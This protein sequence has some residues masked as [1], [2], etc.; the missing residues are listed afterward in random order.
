MKKTYM[1]L[2][3]LLACSIMAT[4]ADKDL[5][6]KVTGADR[7]KAC[8]GESL[9]YYDTLDPEECENVALVDGDNTITVPDQLVLYITPVNP[10]DL[11]SFK[12]RDGDPVYRGNSG[13]YEIHN[14][15]TFY[16]P[17]TIVCASE[18]E[19][20]NQSVTI[21]MDDCSKVKI[22]RADQKVFEPETNTITIP[23]NPQ[24]ESRLEIRP[25]SSDYQLYKVLVDG[26]EAT[27]GY[28][29]FYA[30]LVDYSG[31]EPVYA[32]NIDV[33]ANYPE[34]FKFKVSIELDAPQE[35][36]T[37]IK[38]DGKEVGNID[39]YLTAEGFDV[40]PFTV[41]A[42]GLD[43]RNYDITKLTDNDATKYA[44]SQ[45]TIDGIDCDHHIVIAGKKLSVYNVTINVTGA[46]GIVAEYN[47]N[48]ITFVEGE[49]TL[50]AT[51]TSNY[52]TI[53]QADGWEIRS[54]TDN[55]GN[56]YL[57]YW[58]N[59]YHTAEIRLQENVT[60]NIDAVKIERNNRIVVYFDEF[61]LNS[62]DYFVCG[63]AEYDAPTSQVTT[64]YNVINFRDEDGEFKLYA[65][66]YSGA[67][68]NLI[69][70]KNGEL[71]P[72]SY[73]GAKY[74]ED[75]DVADKDVYKFFFDNDPGTH[76]SLIPISEPTRRS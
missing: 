5:T 62:L 20:R 21:N 25:R 43:N 35:M 13:W 34:D 76:L 11:F 3:A 50:K 68:S 74:R 58:W 14:E 33:T 48:S 29:G 36:I 67:Y 16:T 71:M 30:D 44:Y 57:D 18:E 1:F 73:E 51:K 27:K 6:L 63:F 10:D 47:S 46:E 23:Y 54:I 22:I 75:E 15:R 55:E 59:Y 19:Y 38:L 37:Y 45:Y 41:I 42:I 49:N 40:D 66:T 72:A 17:Y 28:S 8:I 32:K 56:D 70:Y 65:S 2:V 64:G 12:D 53:G 60:Y 52:L 26:K 61:D 4:A 24:E 39:E 69:A 7:I 9:G 31:D